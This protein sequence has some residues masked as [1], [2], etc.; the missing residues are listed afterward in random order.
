MVTYNISVND[1]LAEEFER[2]MK[3][4][5]YANRSECFRDLIRQKVAVADDYEIEEV[6]PGDA[7]YQLIQKRK[8]NNDA[9]FVPL[10]DLI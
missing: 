2:Y 6:L 8:K 9:N 7:D 10:Q 1:E 3:R 5:K 4:K